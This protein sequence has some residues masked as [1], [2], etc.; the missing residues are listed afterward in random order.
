M[1]YG[2]LFVALILNLIEP[3]AVLKYFYPNILLLTAM[4]WAVKIPR[5][6]N[7]GH[8]FM[9][10][11]LL[12]LLVG[13]TLGI[14]AFAFSLMFFMLTSAFSKLETYSLLQQSVSIAIISFVGQIVTF[15]LEHLFGLAFIDYHT[16]LSCVS[17][18]IF[19]PV[20]WVSLGFLMRFRHVRNTNSQ[21]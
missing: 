13:S 6:V 3:P 9:A 1:V 5:M 10:G 14:K 4:F 16:I 7:V 21:F 12:D 19:W 2:S 11:L 18:M 15:W 17:D 20:L 8:G